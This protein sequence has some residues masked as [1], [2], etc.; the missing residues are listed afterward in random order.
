MQIYPFF[1][2]FLLNVILDVNPYELEIRFQG[3]FPVEPVLS[4]VQ[5]E[6]CQTS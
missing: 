6:F 1:F 2:F 5:T 4:C 3:L